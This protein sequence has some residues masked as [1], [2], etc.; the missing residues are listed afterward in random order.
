MEPIKYNVAENE[1]RVH[2]NMVNLVETLYY[3]CHANF[4]PKGDEKNGRLY[5]IPHFPALMQAIG[6]L[7]LDK[8]Y[9]PALVDASER[10]GNK[11]FWLLRNCEWIAGNPTTPFFYRCLSYRDP[12]LVTHKIN[13]LL[14]NNTSSLPCCDPELI[15][16][17]P[18]PASNKEEQDKVQWLIDLLTKSKRM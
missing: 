5:D 15:E 1:K 16:K 9:N 14:H 8:S 3:F 11:Y 13:P 10:Y 2:E 18:F 12:F 6:R 4:M 17:D 7:L